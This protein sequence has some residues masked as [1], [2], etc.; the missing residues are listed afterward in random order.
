MDKA[1]LHFF[2]ISDTMTGEITC[3]N[4]GVVLSE[5]A[6]GVWKVVRSFLRNSKRQ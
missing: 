5:K 4:C 3:G 1:C 6:L 2:K